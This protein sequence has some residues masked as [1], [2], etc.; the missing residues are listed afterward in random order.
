M[1]PNPSS[2]SAETSAARSGP[3]TYVVEAVVAIAIA[4]MGGVVIYGS[5]ALGSGWT[6]DGPGAGYFPF[7]IGLILCASGLATAAQALFSKNKNTEVFV[8]GPSRF[9]IGN[10]TS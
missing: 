6:S 4:V 9:S 8:D 5:R 7:Y 2:E 10:A 1:E 3:A